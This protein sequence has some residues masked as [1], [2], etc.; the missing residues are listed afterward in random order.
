MRILLICAALLGGCDTGS[1]TPSSARASASTSSKQTTQPKAG[2]A[3][4][5]KKTKKVS[6]S[7]G[8]SPNQLPGYVGTF[9]NDP[10]LSAERVAAWA[11]KQ[12]RIKRNEVYA[13]YGR[14]FSSDDLKAHF[15][16]QGWYEVRSSYSDTLLTAND[17]AN[18]SLIKSFEGEPKRWDGQVGELMF[19]DAR[20]LVI[21]DA[22][23]L[24]GHEGEERHY[25]ARGSQYVI[26]WSGS[27]RFDLKSS[28]V[29]QAELWT[30]TRSGWSRTQ[31][32]VPNG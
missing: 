9:K 7:S 23:S 22:D 27:P 18:V 16:R 31:I 11:P 2:G 24:Y 32:K 4:G 30:R 6:A 26:T 25:V 19:M 3:T 8:K 15:G 13:R 1:A 10:K 17:R 5:Q 20:S 29:T 12:L 14:A 28:S 21:S